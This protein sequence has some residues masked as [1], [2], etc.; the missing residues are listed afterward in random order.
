MF[1][2]HIA[3][4]FASKRFAPRTSLGLLLG[5]T[6][7]ADLLWPVLLAFGLER[8]RIDSTA[9]WSN[10]DFVSYPW[11][12]SLAALVFWATV[13]AGI[14]WAVT[15]YRPGAVLIWIGVVSHWVLDWITHRPDMPLWPGSALYGV[16]LWNSIAGTMTVELGMLAAGLWLYLRATRARD[17]IGLYAMAAFVALIVYIEISSP[18]GAPPPSVSAI[19]WMSVIAEPILLVWAWWFDRHRTARSAAQSKAVPVAG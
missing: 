10:L 9:R 18:F 12:H 14:Y 8:V 17:R 5:A 13:C 4:G 2:G 16:G 6:M 15:R 7:F 19:V 1:I 3:V 11:S